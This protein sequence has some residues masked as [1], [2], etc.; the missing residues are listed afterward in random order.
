MTSVF[1]NRAAAVAVVCVYM[2]VAV[3][4]L[5]PGPYFPTFEAEYDKFEHMLA[6]AFLAFITVIALQRRFNSLAVCLSIVVFGGVLELGQFFVPGREVA[7]GD[8]A[9]N[10]FGA[11]IGT[12]LSWRFS[13]E[14]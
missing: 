4:S 6:Y 10:I 7:L 3:L 9:A 1:L 5:L 2:S 14:L 12:L 8:F 13:A 11:V